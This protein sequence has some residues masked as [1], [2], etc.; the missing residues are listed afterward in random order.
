M[1]TVIIDPH[2]DLILQVEDECISVSSKVLSLVSPVF[3]AMM[4]P[5]FK[6]GIELQT[7]K[8]TQSTISL[9]E[10]DIEALIIF[11]KVIHHRAHE[12]PQVPSPSCLEKLAYICDKY[13]CTGSMRA[14]GTLWLQR[15]FQEIPSED[16]NR[17]LLFAYV[18]DLSKSFS[19]ISAEVLSR[20]KGPFDTLPALS[21]HQLVRHDLLEPFNVE[22]LRLSLTLHRAI[23]Q[24]ISNLVGID[25]EKTMSTIG[26]YQCSLKKNGVYP[27][28]DNFEKQSFRNIADKVSSI[29]EIY[30]DSCTSWKC[31]CQELKRSGLS[32]RL[33]QEIQRWKMSRQGVC[34][35]CV[36]TARRSIVE[37]KCGILHL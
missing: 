1:T 22:K 34:L 18:L 33:R 2:G 29:S 7:V 12:I 31:Q 3:E 23:M 36:K 32:V 14:Y 21:N 4:K 11:C 8:S 15:N 30:I 25:C 6:E 16:L 19:V 24:P 17:L 35:D 13:Q 9:H 37:G 26:R 27:Y 5:N 10:D 28:D 20:Q